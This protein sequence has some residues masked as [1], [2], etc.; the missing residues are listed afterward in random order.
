MLL[1]GA[2]RRAHGAEGIVVVRGDDLAARVRDGN[3]VHDP[4]AMVE[5]RLTV[6][7]R[8]DQHRSPPDVIGGD[9]ARTVGLEQDAPGAVAVVQRRAGPVLTARTM[10]ER[11]VRVAH[12]RATLRHEDRPVLGIVL[13]LVGGGARDHVAISVVAARS[14]AHGGDATRAVPSETLTLDRRGA[15]GEHAL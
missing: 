5:A 7:D 13:R 2:R 3:D 10:T 15:D 11:V 14:G 12:A 4:V 1:R 9:G 8:G 6:D